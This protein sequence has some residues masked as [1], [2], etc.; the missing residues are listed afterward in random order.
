M[1]LDPPFFPSMGTLITDEEQP[2]TA[3]GTSNCSRPI[4]GLEWRS[5]CSSGMLSF[6][7]VCVLLAC[8]RGGETPQGSLRS[9]HAT[10]KEVA[11]DLSNRP[12][13][14]SVEPVVR[15]RVRSYSS[16][17]LA[18]RVFS[19][20]SA[21]QRLLV[22]DRALRRPRILDAPVQVARAQG[23][24]FITGADSECRAP[25]DSP[26]AIRLIDDVS[27]GLLIDDVRLPGALDLVPKGEG[28]DLVARLPM[29]T[30]LPGVVQGELFQG[31]PRSTF[32]A[33]AVAA[34]SYAVAES[35]FWRDRRHYDVVAGPASQAWIGLDTSEAAKEAVD[36]TRG[37]VILYQGRVV[38]AYYSSCCGGRSAAASEAI[39]DRESHRIRPLDPRVDDVSACCEESGVRRWTASFRRDQ[40]TAALRAL[41][42]KRGIKALEQ[43]QSVRKISLVETND[44]GRALRFRLEDGAGRVAHLD[45]RSLRQV[46]NG[47]QRADG[48]D[49]AALRSDDFTVRLLGQKVRLEGRGYGHGV[50]LCQY[51]AKA[52]G[53]NGDDW[54]MILSRYYP[55]SEI[56]IAWTDGE[57]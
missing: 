42:G 2:M 50:G 11:P 22:F 24:W 38:P 37:A 23:S 51:G 28:V 31:W 7:L 35:S 34:R 12:L 55:E 10:A 20:G 57:E 27:A 19:F 14:P 54:R 5:W 41:G 47:L 1:P 56:G 8:E 15:V 3:A 32:Q 53:R 39:S 49:P 6:L 29:E 36:S 45:A 16:E 9:G 4:L 18:D 13:P 25:A 17:L 44:A 21:G 26:L 52:M 30:Y 48:A 33:Q 46:F 43:F 40:L